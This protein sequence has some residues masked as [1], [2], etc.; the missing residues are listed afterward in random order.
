MEIGVFEHS[1]ITCTNEYDNL[2]NQNK[3][4]NDSSSKISSHM[5]CDVPCR[6]LADKFVQPCGELLL[7]DVR[8]PEFESNSCC[9]IGMTTSIPIRSALIGYS[10]QL[11]NL[12]NCHYCSVVRCCW[13]PESRRK[14]EERARV[15][16]YELVKSGRF[17]SLTLSMH[18]ILV[19]GRC[20]LP[21]SNIAE[22]IELSPPIELLLPIA[23][24]RP[25]LSQPSIEDPVLEICPDHRQEGHGH[26]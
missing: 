6:I 22:S 11:R 9:G 14:D 10:T 24:R 15:E 17:V 4:K 12:R 7:A 21:L 2:C 20:S 3:C 19:L 18:L 1:C 5:R 25:L 8:A 23:Q 16:S 13:G 26:N